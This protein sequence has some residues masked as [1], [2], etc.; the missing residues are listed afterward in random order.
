[1]AR[2]LQR[3]NV[4]EAYRFDGGNIPFIFAHDK[5]AYISG[6]KL[7]VKQASGNVL[8]VDPGDWIVRGALG[9]LSVYTDNL[10][11]ANFEELP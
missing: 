3:Q 5:R 8:M 2:Y 6:G 10:F 7:K 9:Q 1:M 11:K 4:V